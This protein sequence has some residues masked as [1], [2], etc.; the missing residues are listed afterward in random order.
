MKVRYNF[1]YHVDK[2]FEDWE[3]PVL[4]KCKEMGILT[5]LEENINGHSHLLEQLGHMC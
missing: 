3:Y 1:T 4:I 5:L 2:N